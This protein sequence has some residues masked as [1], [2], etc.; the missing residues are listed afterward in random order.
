MRLLHYMHDNDAVPKQ[1][2][3]KVIDAKAAQRLCAAGSLCGGA[4]ARRPLSNAVGVLR[5]RRAGVASTAL[6][7][8]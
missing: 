1:I 5:R 8:S 2:I 3:L 6:W 4:S 7:F